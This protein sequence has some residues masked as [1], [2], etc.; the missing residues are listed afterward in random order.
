MT[1]VY[2]QAGSGGFFSDPMNLVLI[3]ATMFVIYFFMLRPNQKR[4]KEGKDFFD[5][6]QKGD[7]IITAGGIH[8]KVV[9]IGE[10]S[11]DI[12]IS[13]NNVMTVEK[14][15]ISTELSIAFN[16]PKEEKK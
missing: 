3:S 11:I 9:K 15:F 5:N 10:T 7:K 6:L 13:N 2:L 16:K 12:E 8:G 1:A 4:A 14:N